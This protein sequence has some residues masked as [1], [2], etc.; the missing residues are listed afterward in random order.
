M[1]SFGSFIAKMLG[2][3]K[4]SLEIHATTTNHL[5]Y[6]EFWPEKSLSFSV[7][8]ILKDRPL[9]TKKALAYL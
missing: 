6:A 9:P 7:V 5:L 8:D 4:M 1:S 3:S 2:M